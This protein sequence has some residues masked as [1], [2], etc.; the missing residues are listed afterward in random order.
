MKTKVFS[1]LLLFLVGAL[2]PK[3]LHSQGPPTLSFTRHD[4]ILGGNPLGI[5]SADF[6]G[7]GKQDLAVLYGPSGATRTFVAM[8]LGNGDGTFTL[9]N[10]FDTGFA[11]PWLITADLN[12]DNRPDLV[13]ANGFGRSISV[14]LGNGDGTFGTSN[15]VPLP[16]RI[17]SVI[18]GDFNGDG[19]L[20]LAAPNFEPQPYTVSILLGNGDGTF[21]PS[22]E[23]PTLDVP[24]IVIADDFNHD[25][26]L[27][28]ALNTDQGTVSVIGSVLLGNGDGTFQPRKDFATGF[29]QS[30]DLASGD[31]NSDG[32]TDLVVANNAD[33]SVSILLGS[34]D[35]TFTPQSSIALPVTPFRLVT[36]DVDGDGKMDLVVARRNS[37]TVSIL[38]GKGDGTFGAPADFDTGLGPQFVVVNDLNGDSKLDPVTANTDDG[39]VSILLNTTAQ[40][41]TAA[42]TINGSTAPVTVLVTSLVA[43]NANPNPVSAST[44]DWNPGAPLPGAF[45]TAAGSSCAPSSPIYTA[46]AGGTFSEN[47]TVTNGSNSVTSSC[48]SLTVQDFSLSVTPPSATALPGGVAIYTVTASSINGFTG[49]INFVQS[50]TLPSGISAA[51]SP[52]SQFCTVPAGGSCSAT[53][54]VTVGAGASAGDTG[55]AFHGTYA[56]A[57]TTRDA[58]A[59]LHVPSPAPIITS[60]SP[61]SGNQG[62][63]LTVTVTGS[64]FLPGA[65]LY[66]TGTGPVPVLS[67]PLTCNV[68]CTSA[69]ATIVIPASAIIQLKDVVATNP[70]SPPSQ[71][72]TNAFRIDREMAIVTGPAGEPTIAIDPVNP[73]HIVVGFNDVSTTPHRC[74]W[75]ETID[76]GDNWSS[77][78]AFPLPSGYESVDP[79]VRFGPNGELIYMC[80]ALGPGTTG[81]YMTI[82]RP[83]TG[84][85]SLALAKNFSPATA[86]AKLKQ[87]PCKISDCPK[88]GLPF[89][90]H[91]SLSV[92]KR[93]ASFRIVACW[94][95]FFAFQKQLQSLVEGAYSNGGQGWTETTLGAGRLCATG[96][97]GS[98]VTGPNINRVAATWLDDNADQLKVRTS[99]TG[100]RWNSPLI[101]GNVDPKHSI[102]DKVFVSPSSFIATSATGPRAISELRLNGKSSVLFTDLTSLNNTFID[103]AAHETF[104][105]GMGFCGKVVGAYTMV[106]AGITPADAPF[107]YTAW[108]A[109][110]S[111]PQLI[112]TSGQDLLGANAFPLNA[113]YHTL[114]EYT[115][116]DCSTQSAWVAWTDVRNGQQIWAAQIPL[117]H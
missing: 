53:Y 33:D 77:P 92:L 98:D 49:Q 63:T 75:V 93:G 6:N 54:T 111:N 43:Y 22:T 10:T 91:P 38:V 94:S 19:K 115:A 52:T 8:F 29:M 76:G 86:V 32:K 81:I 79:W 15:V 113:Q 13:I 58:S 103:G 5:A 14:L 31:F 96:G 105:P 17:E 83:S 39:T 56:P 24:F 37:A 97:D 99:A 95:L 4:L 69:T 3:F 84:T 20:D 46:V 74:G 51:W 1:L 90:D 47:V 102:T 100:I 55:F 26:K 41:L 9:L 16:G 71:V 116:A 66:L 82:S 114:N 85:G 72:L 23:Y 34:G 28:L 57:L 73:S 109:T 80:A 62:Q 68:P 101:L 40:T 45:D 36:R 87:G 106:S 88:Q 30:A 48:P 50:T 18:A 108:D 59:T 12:H 11:A 70:G 78:G 110:A 7:D 61:L 117:R 112:F 25:G 89:L 2:T 35:G 21:G 104:I 64:N 44:C 27:D 107:R 65:I 60:I 42:C 67:S